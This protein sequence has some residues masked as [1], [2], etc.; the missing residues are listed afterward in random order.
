MMFICLIMVCFALFGALQSGFVYITEQHEEQQR[1]LNEKTDE[2][3]KQALKVVCKRYARFIN[4][5]GSVDLE[6]S[7]RYI[8]NIEKERRRKIETISFEVLE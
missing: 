6:E 5:D 7:R 2:I 8:A 4:P 3:E 1:K